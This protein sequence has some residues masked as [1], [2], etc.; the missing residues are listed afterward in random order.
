MRA[1]AAGLLAILAA[2][3]SRPPDTTSAAPDAGAPPAVTAIEPAA[4]A[5]APTAS[6]S[7]GAPPAAVTAE[8]EVAGAIA[9]D[10]GLVD[11]AAAGAIARNEVPGVVVAVVHGGRTVFQRAYGL[12]SKELE[13]HTMTVDT[14]FDL[15][16][17]TKVVV[18]APSVQLLIEQGKIKL[19]D[20]VAKHLP[21]FGKNGKDRVTVE[22]LLF[23]TS[24]LVADNSIAD[25]RGGK[26]DALARIDALPLLSEPGEKFS[27]SDVGYIVLGELVEA[28]SGEPLDAFA[29]R[30]LFEPLGMRDTGFVPSPALA[31]RAAPTEP[32]DG[33]MLQ[34]V[35]HDPR[36]HALG[37][38]AGHAGL[39][40]T[41]PDLARFVAMLLAKGRRAE[42][43]IFPAP[44]L[45][46]MT[47]PHE[48]PGGVRRTLGWDVRP[49]FTGGSGYGHTGFTG[50]SLWI[51]PG[52]DT[53]MIVL[54]SR[55][56]PD[57]KGDVGRLRREVAA[58]VARPRVA[59]P[60]TAAP[61]AP[62]AKPGAVRV[63]IDVLERDGFPPLKGRKIGLITNQTGIDHAGRSTVDVLRGA[64]GVTLVALFT[65]EHGLRGAADGRV[66][67]GLDAKTGLPVYSLYGARMRPTDAQLAGIDTLV[68]DLQDAGARFYTFA[69]T[70]GYLLEVA[71]EHHLRMVVLDRPN[72]TGGVAVEG[73][74]L[75]AGRSSFTEYH[76]VPLRHGM[77]LGELS[78]LYNAERKI[79]AELVVARLEG[80]RRDQ[81]FER[82]GLVW[83][84]PSPNLR[85]VDEALLYPGVALL[86]GTNV[87]VG[88]GTDRP[89]EYVGAPFVDGQRLAAALNDL[90]LPGARFAE[91]AFTPK[92]GVHAGTPCAG[93]L[94]GVADRTKIEPVRVGLAI[95]EALLRLHPAD[96]QPQGMRRMIGHEPTYLAVLRGDPLDAIVAS[97]QADLEAFAAV[98]KKYLLYE[99]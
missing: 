49:G 88:R 75:E 64:E 21:G 13:E 68:F 55:L 56:H 25:Y 86:D 66:S 22:H 90:H 38:V 95:A 59:P 70:L 50:T 52:T 32:R 82:T 1:L 11:S 6:A 67:D 74:V 20:P 35:V 51:D 10:A 96:F 44:A 37:G 17:L 89:F 98:R 85:T 41:A 28:V 45:L 72:P 8:P 79:G 4:S 91:A 15:A 43:Q 92:S 7:A 9:V 12:R 78:H 84:S 26:A 2:A 53:G 54:T 40:S 77:T 47:E 33:T 18:T 14:V 29:R 30:N 3:C 57:G 34:G 71:A 19:G 16:S 31:A 87:S 39:F 46:R 24:G 83:V 63:G 23:H 48:L 93:V 99:P 60:P 36:A 81:T 94:V 5:A 80:W 27:Y 65:P 42:A 62:A 69:T 61:V 73:P 97:W 58:A 76:P